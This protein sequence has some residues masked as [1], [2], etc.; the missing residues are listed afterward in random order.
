MMKAGDLLPKYL[1]NELKALELDREMFCL[2]H[3]P[4]W[5]IRGCS[6][7]I[8]DHY[9]RKALHSSRYILFPK[10]KGKSAEEDLL[11][12][13]KEV[14]E[15]PIGDIKSILINDMVSGGVLIAEM[16]DGTDKAYL[17]RFTATRQ[18]L[19]NLGKNS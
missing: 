7:K 17:C 2:P 12:N 15:Y 19:R 10:E 6:A 18:R 16:E 13:L 4:I 9:K 1:D 14:K 3:L 11:F 5:I 8:G